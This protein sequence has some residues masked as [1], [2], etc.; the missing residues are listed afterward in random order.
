ME[1]QQ[2]GL[3]VLSEQTPCP[4]FEFSDWA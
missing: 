2:D 4:A 3:L 1:A